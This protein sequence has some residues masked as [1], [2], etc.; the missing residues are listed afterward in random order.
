MKMLTELRKDWF[1][2]LNCLH[3]AHYIVFTNFLYNT[4]NFTL[5]FPH[6]IW[7][8]ICCLQGDD[9]FCDAPFPLSHLNKPSSE[10]LRNPLFKYGNDDK[11]EETV[12]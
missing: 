11:A 12:S 9:D 5:I 1:D 4:C 6:H 10:M 8:K 3:L 7:P 2:Y